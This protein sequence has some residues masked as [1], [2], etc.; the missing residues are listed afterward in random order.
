MFAMKYIPTDFSL[1]C[2]KDT[3]ITDDL[4]RKLLSL[5]LS[6]TL[7]LLSTS[8]LFRHNPLLVTRTDTE[9]SP[10]RSA[11][12]ACHCE[13][14]SNAPKN[15]VSLSPTQKS[16]KNTTLPTLNT[17]M[18]ICSGISRSCPRPPLQVVQQ[19]SLLPSS[20]FSYR[21]FQSRSCH[22]MSL[23]PAPLDSSRTHLAVLGDWV[24]RVGRNEPG[25][26]GP[27]HTLVR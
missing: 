18:L 24:G 20:N 1:F 9:V 11:F 17:H 26:Q 10:D 14:A 25:N 5:S 27:K 7:T 19:D 21:E 2:S 4:R 13:S 22:R 23:L 16:S 3:F 12:L 8:C 15:C 6:L